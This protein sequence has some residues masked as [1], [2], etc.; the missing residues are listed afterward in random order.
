M[1]S[2]LLF[3]GILLLGPM[4]KD[5]VAKYML[6]EV[7]EVRVGNK[8]GS[9]FSYYYLEEYILAYN[10]IYLDRFLLLS[11]ILVARQTSENRVCG[12][13]GYYRGPCGYND[14][15]FDA[16]G[17]IVA[18]LSVGR[19]DRCEWN[20]TIRLLTYNDCLGMCEAWNSAFRRNDASTQGFTNIPCVGI[21]TTATDLDSTVGACNLVRSRNPPGRNNPPNPD[22]ASNC[23]GAPGFFTL[24]YASHRPYRSALS[25]R[26]ICRYG[27]NSN[28]NPNL[29]DFTC[30][31]IFD[32][33]RYPQSEDICTQI[34]ECPAR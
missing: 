28:S 27:S 23:P 16:D 17:N 14:P 26:D 31:A 5:S 6:V 24:H 1:K 7:D 32:G 11:F 30:F 3:M 19:A 33:R 8:P 10:E 20:T 2:R 29:P 12:A 34:P 25:A 9:I 13:F 21:E 15:I 22:N 18:R 4:C